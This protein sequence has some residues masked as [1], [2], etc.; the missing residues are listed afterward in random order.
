LSS[1][2]KSIVARHDPAHWI[3]SLS[4][5]AKAALPYDPSQAAQSAPLLFDATVYIDHLKGELPATI[6]N[7]VA[8]RVI[9]H[10]APAL[11]ELAV[12]VGV[13]DPLDTRTNNTLKPL[14]ELLERISPQRIIVP[15]YDAWL[16]AAVLAGILARTQGIPRTDRRK[17]LSDALL[18]LMAAESRSIMISRNSRD[19]DL[20][21][22]MKPSVMVLLYE[23]A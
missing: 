4:Y 6:V 16:E 20:L 15:S 10:G 7:L 12:T 9:L 1:D 2:V 5:R 13:L 14:V 8:S 11:A 18:F 23:K 17:L 3:R 22:Q 21:L 19:F